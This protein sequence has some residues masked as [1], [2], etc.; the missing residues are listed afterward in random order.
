MVLKG[1]ELGPTM[2]LSSELCWKQRTRNSAT[3]GW[4]FS[5]LGFSSVGEAAVG[6]MKGRLLSHAQSFSLLQSP[7]V[8]TQARSKLLSW[9]GILGA[10]GKVIPCSWNDLTTFCLLCLQYPQNTHVFTEG[11]GLAMLSLLARVRRSAPK[12]YPD[13]QKQGTCSTNM[14]QKISF[15]H[16][17]SE[18]NHFSWLKRHKAW[19]LPHQQIKGD[20]RTLQ[21]TWQCFFLILLS[22]FLLKAAKSDILNF[23]EIHW[24]YLRVRNKDFKIKPNFKTQARQTAMDSGL[25]LS[26]CSSFICMQI[27]IQFNSYFFLNCPAGRTMAMCWQMK[28]HWSFCYGHFANSSYAHSMAFCHSIFFSVNE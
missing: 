27:P 17:E 4:Y 9:T 8:P 20:R 2:C 22:C 18:H 28:R 7:L 21:N 16:Q 12:T 6:G 23:L 15:I 24:Y 19:N 3:A 25:V 5:L 11:W 14:K 10:Y 1:W 26:H 13:R